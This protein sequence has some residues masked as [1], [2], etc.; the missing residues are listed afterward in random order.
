MEEYHECMQITKS[1]RFCPNAFRIDLYRGCDFGCRYC[2]ANNEMFNEQ[3]MTKWRQAKIEKVEKRFFKAL[4]T[5][6]ESKDILVELIRNRVPVHCGGMSDPFQRREWTQ[7]LTYRLIELSNKYQY[8]MVFSTKT[9]Y[10]PE[11]YLQ[12]LDPKIHAFQVSI[13]GWDT[14][15]WETNT[16]S[17]KS[18]LKFVKRLRDRGFWCSI[19]IQPIIDISNVLKLIENAGSIPSYYTVEHLRMI[20][21]TQVG[22]EAFHKLV[23]NKE[24]FINSSHHLQVK[25]DI[26]IQ[27]IKR[28]QAEA[29]KFGVKVGVGD[30]DLHWMSQSRNCCG[31]DTMGESF[32]KYLKYNLT[33][34]STGETD[35]DALWVPKC[36][37]RKHINDVYAGSV[38]DC[39]DYTDEYIKKHWDCVGGPYKQALEKRL[40]GR[41][42]KSLF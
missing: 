34:M 40:F 8:P 3:T 30:N 17:A 9:D 41:V 27:N 20:Y 31:L 18:R 32:Q 7:R 15:K 22:M 42:R 10:L 1:F 35:F 13:M 16:G 6:D 5:D 12:I 21:D 14:E 29:N 23:E 28:I 33:Y 26:K 25:R 36:N 38:I 4:E 24:D 11:E 37:P 19:R 2:F 39:K